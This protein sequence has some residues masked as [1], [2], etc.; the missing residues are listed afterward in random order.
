VS[1][2][3]GRAVRVGAILSRSDLRAGCYLLA[4]EVAM[5]RVVEAGT[6]AFIVVRQTAPA[7]RWVLPRSNV[8]QP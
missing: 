1:A 2:P 3:T 4:H 5:W 7:Q 6:A 8:T